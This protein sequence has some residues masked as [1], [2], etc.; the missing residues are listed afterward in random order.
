MGTA[1]GQEEGARLA[2]V[3][4]RFRTYLSWIVVTIWSA[5]S[6]VAFFTQNFAELGIVTPVMM[7]VVGF[8]FGYK[9]PTFESGDK[10]E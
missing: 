1:L 2:L 4:P 10:K 7:I 8:V 9:A 6:V 5:A 3:S